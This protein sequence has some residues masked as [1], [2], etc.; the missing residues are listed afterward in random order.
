MT[1]SYYRHDPHT[2]AAPHNRAS[3]PTVDLE[4][5]RGAAQQRWRTVTGPAFLIGTAGDCDMVLGDTR[6]PAVH[7]CLLRGA[8]GITVRHLGFEPELCVNDEAV[9]CVTLN[10][11][12]RIQIGRFEFRLHITDLKP[13]S[14]VTNGPHFGRNLL[15]RSRA[16]RSP[17]DQ[18]RAKIRDL[19]AE[20]RR[21]ETPPTT[22]KIYTG[23][24][25]GTPAQRQA[26][27]A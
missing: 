12:D 2:L 6:L 23:H 11:G 5:T 9:D 22:L 15:T 4:I 20:I 21:L 27:L 8:Q 7:T 26:R 24:D 25:T 19:L 3:V 10:D 18:A 1:A 14:E 17:D 16:R 13:T